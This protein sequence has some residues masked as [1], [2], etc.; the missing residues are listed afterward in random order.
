VRPLRREGLGRYRV[1]RAG[2]ILFLFGVPLFLAAADYVPPAGERPAVRRPGAESVL[3]GGR[4]VSPLGQQFVAGARPRALAVNPAGDTVVTADEGV[5][6]PLTVLQRDGATWRRSVVVDEEEKDRGAF[7][8]VVFAGE[9]E[10]FASEGALG[11]VRLTD[12]RSGGRKH[13][14]ELN[15]GGAS[16]SF[17]GEIAFDAKRKALF[18]L[19]ETNARLVI[20]DSG[21]RRVAGQVKLGGA[22]FGLAL[23]PDGRRVYATLPRAG[24]VVVVDVESAASPKLVKTIKWATPRRVLAA[25]ERVFVCDALR[26]VVGVFSAR[27]LELE[28]EV[29]LRVPGFENLRGALPISLHYEPANQWVM[30]VEAGINAIGVIDAR[31]LA[32]LGHLPAAWS[33][34]RAAVHEGR[35]FVANWKGL[36]TGPNASR[37][38][39][40]LSGAREELDRGAVSIYPLPGPEDLAALT[41]KVWENNGFLPS[42]QAAAAVPEGLDH[43]VIVVK[44]KRTFDEVLGDV[45]SA[46]NGPVAAL[47]PVARFG[48]RGVI[49]QKRDELRQRLGLRFVNVT[50]NHHMLAETY[51]FSDNFYADGVVSADGDE[52]TGEPSSLWDHLEKHGVSFRNFGEG[53]AQRDAGEAVP[54]PAD[55]ELALKPDA[56]YRNSSRVYPGFSLNVPDTQ[57]ASLFASEMEREYLDAG[58]PLPRLIL[59]HLP[60]DTLG[61]A[62]PE[63]GYPFEASYMADNDYALGRIVQFLSRTPDWKRMAVFVMEEGASGGA[64]H[65]DSHR[66]LLLAAGPFARPNFCSHLNSNAAAVWKLASRVLRIPPL[67]LNDAAAADLAGM[68]SAEANAAEYTVQPSTLEIF[69]PSKARE[70]V[71]ASSAPAGDDLRGLQ[72]RRKSP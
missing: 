49:V 64:D 50:P 13:F 37:Q 35:A 19:D 47:P 28:R 72:R 70:P 4:V 39:P 5:G 1:E 29:E 53:F 45:E 46:A 2:K 44:G 22:P 15:L 24:A 57:R 56:L 23:S 61:R 66:T 41:K 59:L 12:A 36:G 51:A 52:W 67:G 17:A 6:F 9:R 42:K 7:H 21:R 40:I 18:V 65:V 69:D 10:L 58:K 25:G 26:D 30:V 11:R 63:D 16:D 62:R 8:S 55:G 32:V 68:F 38:G 71:E 27:S 60:G 31:R 43:V 48:R 54:R 33:P 20:F 34:V 3:P 14:Y